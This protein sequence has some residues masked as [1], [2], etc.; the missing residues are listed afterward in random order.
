MDQDQRSSFTLYGALLLDLIWRMRNKVAHEGQ[1]ITIEELYRGLN[2]VFLEHGSVAKGKQSTE[3]SRQGCRWYKPDPEYIKINS[4]AAIA[5]NNFVLAIVAKDRRG[6]VVFAHSKKAH[7]NIPF[8]ALW[9]A[10][11][12]NLQNLI[13]ESDSKICIEAV[14]KNGS[15]ILRRISTIIKD[16]MDLASHIP[17]INY[18]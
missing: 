2:K 13:I 3:N 9:V 5:H 10:G 17:S 15:D 7:T 4:D 6:N 14:S 11:Q 18:C 8:Q 16:F 1:L 12:C